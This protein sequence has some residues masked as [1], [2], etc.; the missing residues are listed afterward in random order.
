VLGKAPASLQE[1]PIVDDSWELWTLNDTNYRKQVPRWTRHFELHP[2]EWTKAPEYDQYHGWLSQSH[3]KPIM[4]K[5]DWTEVVDGVLY[6]Y[7]E[8]REF[9]Q[10]DYFTNTISYMLALAIYEVIHSQDKD[11]HIGLWGVDMAQSGVGG[12]SEYA[13]QRPSCEYFIG[14]GRGLGIPIHIPGSCDLLKTKSMYGMDS[15]GMETKFRAREQE[16]KARIADAQQREQA[17]HD[18][19]LYLRGAVDGQSYT[20]QFLHFDH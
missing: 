7:G 11:A 20:Y 12:K 13:A 10:T 4:V 6:P 9:F 2:I 18:E 14:F 3:G 8:M 1:A 17:A 16:L 5:D 19:A 15:H